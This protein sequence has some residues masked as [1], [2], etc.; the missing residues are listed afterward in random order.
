MATGENW[1]VERFGASLINKK[2]GKEKPTDMIL[3]NKDLILVYFSASWC[4]PCKMFTPVL[5]SFY[6]E[7]CVP[8]NVEIIYLSSDRDVE[9]FNEYYGKMPWTAIPIRDTQETKQQLANALQVTS[10]PHLVVLNKDGKFVTDQARAEVMEIAGSK[11]KG[12]ALVAEWKR[13]EG[14][15]IE[16]AKFS[17][18]QSLLMK[19][20]LFLAKNPIYL[21]GILYMGKKA[22]TYLQELGEDDE[23]DAIK[24]GEL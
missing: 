21:F 7:C 10:I 9:S 18:K 12:E 23:D 11:E 15:D 19:V 17:G 22:L 24:D 14:V 5:T 8:N 2:D 13:K 6:K 4:P 3:K 20:V 1:K 16:N